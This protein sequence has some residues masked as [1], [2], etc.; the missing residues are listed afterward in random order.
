[1]VAVETAIVKLRD[2]A[3]QVSRLA[4]DSVI[5]IERSESLQCVRSRALR[6]VWPWAGREA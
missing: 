6:V 3:S 2:G 4:L 5:G 1:M